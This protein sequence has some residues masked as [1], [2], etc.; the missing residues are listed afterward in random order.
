MLRLLVPHA[1]LLVAGL[2]GH[3][4]AA[5]N[6]GNTVDIFGLATSND[7]GTGL[8]KGDIAVALGDGSVRVLDLRKKG[9]VAAVLEVRGKQ[10]TAGALLLL[11]VL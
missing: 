7:N 1:S 10:V 11:L 2:Q 5:R 9:A 4:G 6:P 8:G 3:G